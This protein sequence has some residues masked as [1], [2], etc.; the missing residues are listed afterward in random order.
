MCHDGRKDS[1][2]CGRGTI[3]NQEIL[4]CDYW[5]ST[6]CDK[7]PSFYYVNQQ[8]G[9]SGSSWVPPS[10]G[11]QQDNPSNFQD[12]N[13]RQNYP[14]NNGNSGGNPYQPAGFDSD[15]N[16]QSGGFGPN[17]GG[18]SGG[19]GTN[20]G[21]QSGGYGSNNDGPSGGFGSNNNG[22]NGN[23][24]CC[25]QKYSYKTPWEFPAS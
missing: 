12:A 18:Q 24:D 16:G 20:N 13:Y 2:L 23:K 11:Y 9:S 17:N 21:G 7:A 6:E 15:S 8:I 19:F 4:A 10:G 5:Y 25:C 22:Q 3:F 14:N 1:F